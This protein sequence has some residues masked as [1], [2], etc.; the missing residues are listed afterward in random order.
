MNKKLIKKK[1]WEKFPNYWKLAITNCRCKTR[2]LTNV[3]EAVSLEAKTTS[4]KID[5][6]INAHSHG[7]F[8]MVFSFENSPE[9]LDYWLAVNNW[10][11]YYNNQIKS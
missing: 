7:S 6:I 11:N 10:V 8:C 4:N 2:F 3:A 9:G 5:D 1:L